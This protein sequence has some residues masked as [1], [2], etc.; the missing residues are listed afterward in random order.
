MLDEKILQE[1]A[2][3]L[4]AETGNDAMGPVCQCYR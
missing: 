3:A 1:K 4:K 2:A